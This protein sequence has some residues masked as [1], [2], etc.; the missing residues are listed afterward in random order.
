VAA[1]N[2]L[3]GGWH[4]QDASLRDLLAFEAVID[5]EAEYEGVAR[6]KASFRLTSGLH[7]SLILPHSI[8]ERI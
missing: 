3:V 7:E 5:G 2:A 6:G 8:L 1:H 4:L